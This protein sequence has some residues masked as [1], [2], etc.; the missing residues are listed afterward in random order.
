MAGYRVRL[1][2]QKADTSGGNG[3][4]SAGAPGSG[5]LHVDFAQA[6]DDQYEFE[7]HQRRLEREMRHRQRIEEE[8]WRP[9]SPPPVPHY[10]EHESHVVVEQLK[11]EERFGRAIQILATW[12]ERGD[13]SKRNSN[14]FFSMIQSAHAHLRRLSSEKSQLEDEAKRTHD[15]LR[16]KFLHLTTQREF[17]STF[18]FTSWFHL[19][20]VSVS[21][22]LCSRARSSRTQS[23]ALR[24]GTR[25]FR[26]MQIQSIWPSENV[27]R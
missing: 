21:F 9:P 4:G 3:N 6:R 12:L 11:S 17:L 2:N 23:E 8:K 19:V 5:R 15:S 7:C 22:P 14:G 10:A 27:L 18:F 24:E 26:Y 25:E 13:C 1:N 16:Q 20:V